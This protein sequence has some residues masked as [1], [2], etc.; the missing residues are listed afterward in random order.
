[1]ATTTSKN[2]VRINKSMV[3]KAAWQVLKSK[4]AK[5]LAEAL[6]KA[7]KAYKLKAKMALGVVKFVFKKTNGEIRQAVGTLANNMYQYDY[8]GTGYASSASCIRYFDLERKAFRSFT[9]ASL[10]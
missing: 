4:Q 3:M 5:D 7:W 1:M 9:V 10:L 8:K 6:A 2:N